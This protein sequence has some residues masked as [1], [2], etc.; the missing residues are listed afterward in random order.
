[1]GQSEM[2]HVFII[3]AKSIG[4]YG[5]YE[6][7]IHKLICEHE[8]EGSI[9]YHVACKANGEGCMDEAKLANKVLKSSLGFDENKKL[10]VIVLGSLGSGSLDTIIRDY[11]N[12]VEQKD[13]QVLY[14][15]GKNHY[16]N[17]ENLKLPSNIRIIPFFEDLIGLFKDT[18]VVISRAGAG[19]L[20][21][22][23]ALN[24]PSIVV[25]SPNVANNHQY[26]NAI[27]LKENNACIM[28][29]ENNL[30][31]N[32]LISNVEKILYDDN[33]K[34]EMIKNIKKL[35]IPSS[36]DKIYNAVRGINK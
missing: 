8:N 6:T 21:E 31:A 13:Y 7:F 24:I 16:R 32:T 3:G 11:L 9:K 1:M 19:V 20:N 34:N 14:I 27:S 22:L 36:C 2:Q 30:N 33:F 18:D 35:D 29:E 12:K 15:T 10:V 28:L 5:G 4:Q 25:P 17:Y 26:Y 23:I